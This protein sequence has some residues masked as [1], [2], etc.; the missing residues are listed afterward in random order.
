MTPVAPATSTLTRITRFQPEPSGQP[1]LA[2]VTSLP[3]RDSVSCRGSQDGEGVAGGCYARTGPVVETGKEPAVIP[4]VIL[5]G[6]VFG[7]WSRVTLA[8]LAV[9]WPM[10]LVA[11]GAMRAGPALAGAAGLA[12]LNAGAGVLIHQG[13][14]RGGRNLWRATAA[15]RRT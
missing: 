10:L 12:V 9:G 14:L 1:L 11:T 5:I 4:T 7:R 15:R 8:V 2:L 6:A 13:I 3:N